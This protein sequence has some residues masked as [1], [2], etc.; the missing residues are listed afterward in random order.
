[1]RVG[2]GRDAIDWYDSLQSLYK[3]TTNT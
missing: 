3:T 2:V 1:V